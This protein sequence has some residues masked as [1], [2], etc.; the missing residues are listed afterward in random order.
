MNR[1]LLRPILVIA[2]MTLGLAAP[3]ASAQTVPVGPSGQ[4]LPRFVTLKSTASRVNV[5]QG[6]GVDYEV[7]WVFTRAGLPVEIVQEFD[8]WRRIRDS[9][10][11]SGWVMQTMLSGRRNAVIAPWEKGESVPLRDKPSEQAA[12][13]A[14]LQPGVM[15]QV[16]SCSHNWCRLAD[17]R[18]EGWIKQDRLWGV[19]PGETID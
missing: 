9:D 11:S 8:N 5:R 3:A 14:Y 12:V 2:A 6:P 17:P 18:F 13:A 7:A 16:K 19:Y 10:G 1:N 4:P 15:A